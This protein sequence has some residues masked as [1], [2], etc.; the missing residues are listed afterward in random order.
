MSKTLIFLVCS[1]IFLVFLGVSGIV[2]VSYLLPNKDNTQLIVTIA[3]FVG[4][5]II[6]FVAAFKSTEA[7]TK[8]KENAASIQ[9]LHL[10]VNSRLTQLLEQTALAS[11]LAG[12]AAGAAQIATG[13]IPK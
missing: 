7:V 4:P 3:S 10:V 6:A 5:S 9:S 12:R 2:A 8:G 1:V 13:E 11:N